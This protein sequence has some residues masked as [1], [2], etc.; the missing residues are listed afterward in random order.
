MT[1]VG[2]LNFSIERDDELPAVLIRNAVLVGEA[3][4]AQR[5]EATD[6]E[7][8][9]SLA[10][11]ERV[12]QGLARE[13]DSLLLLARVDASLPAERTPCDLAILAEEAVA[14]TASFA[15]ARGIR[16]ALTRDGPAPR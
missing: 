11:I 13:V 2:V 9:Q 8:Q 15:S 14:A 10:T 16:L 5:P 4:E 3:Q 12:A 1:S 7:R 6:S